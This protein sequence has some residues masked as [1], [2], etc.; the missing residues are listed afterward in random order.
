MG[1]SRRSKC[2]RG[3]GS[4]V[5]EYESTSVALGALVALDALVALGALGEAIY[6]TLSV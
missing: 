1:R 6:L 2:E 5:D 4:C 3:D